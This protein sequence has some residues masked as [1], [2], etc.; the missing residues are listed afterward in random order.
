MNYSP[1]VHNLV[2]ALQMC[3]TDY[4]DVS[5]WKSLQSA[6]LISL[7]N[8]LAK[9]RWDNIFKKIFSNLKIEIYGSWSDFF[10]RKCYKDTKSCQLVFFLF[11]FVV[12][13]R[14]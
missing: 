12:S 5:I 10:P 13:L 6:Y 2:L 7:Q 8:D 3:F 9:K 14:L 1:F 11:L 4:I